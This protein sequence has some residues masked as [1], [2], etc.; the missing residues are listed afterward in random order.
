[1]EHQQQV[2]LVVPEVVLWRLQRVALPMLEDLS[3]YIE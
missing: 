2:R 1:V 3:E